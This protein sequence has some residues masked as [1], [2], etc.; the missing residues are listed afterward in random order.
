MNRV[1]ADTRFAKQHW[2]RR[3][4]ELPYLLVPMSDG[5][6]IRYNPEIVQPGFIETRNNESVVVGYR[7]K[8][9]DNELMD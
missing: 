6:V 2:E 5:R 3:S 9:E 4:D 8:G 1:I 7:R